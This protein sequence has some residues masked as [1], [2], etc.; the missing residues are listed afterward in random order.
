MI[1]ESVNEKKVKLAISV[2]TLEVIITAVFFFLLYRHFKSHPPLY[3]AST[4]H[5]LCKHWWFLLFV[6]IGSSLFSV[7]YNEYRFAFSSLVI[8]PGMAI[9]CAYFGYTLSAS[10]LVILRN[11]PLFKV[12]A[13]INYTVSGIAVLTLLSAQIY[14]WFKIWQQSKEK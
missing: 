5:D 2:F 8:L 12:F 3:L 13:R 6:S 14:I 4:I 11:H 1:S 9:G 10:Y 7:V